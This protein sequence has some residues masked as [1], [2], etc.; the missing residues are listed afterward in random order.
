MHSEFGGI[1]AY[2]QKRALDVFD[3]S[4]LISK[5]PESFT[6]D[7]LESGDRMTD[8]LKTR[9]LEQEKI[10]QEIIEKHQIQSRW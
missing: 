3:S 6:Y 4:N 7:F 10:A 5:L 9:M 2:E 8:E 1:L